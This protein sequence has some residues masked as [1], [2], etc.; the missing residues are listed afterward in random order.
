MSQTLNKILIKGLIDMIVFIEFSED[1]SLDE[2]SSVQLFEG[3]SFELQKL[4]PQEK[5]SLI[6]EIQILSNVYD[7][8]VADFV[9]SIP[10][11]FGL[12]N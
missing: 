2:D 8:D 1:D 11:M 7:A 12:I 6:D 3:L 4:S 10:E 9:R 5:S